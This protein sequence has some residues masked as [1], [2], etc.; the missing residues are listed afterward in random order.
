MTT[1]SEPR[2]TRLHVSRALVAAA[3]LSWVPA[4][5][6]VLVRTTWTGAPTRIPVHWSG[7]GADQWGSTSSLFWTLLVPG[8]AGA[9]LCSVLAVP[10]SAD[11]SRLGAAGV[12]GGITAGTGAITTV[13]VAALLSAA[14]VPAP[15]L[16]VLGAVVWGGVVFGVCLLR[17]AGRSSPAT[18]P[19]VPGPR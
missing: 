11:V 8:L 12:M 5:V 13:W 14:R 10:L 4:L 2:T 9:V 3:A 18:S 19:D 1:T 6:V 17:G 16:V 7:A 15:F